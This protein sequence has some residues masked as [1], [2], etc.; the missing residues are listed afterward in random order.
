M[1]MGKRPH[2]VVVGG[3]WAGASAAS[4]LAEAG[5]SVTLLET[6][7]TLGGRA[8]SLRDGVTRQDVDNGQHAFL[9]AYKET[10]KFLARLGVLKR[11]RFEK[12]LH[13]SLVD[14]TGET[15]VLKSLFPGTAGLLTG[16]LLLKALSIKDKIFLTWGLVRARSTSPRDL[17]KKTVADWLTTIRQT[18]GARRIFWHPLCLATL[19]EEP[20]RAGARFLWTVLHRGLF[21]NQKTRALGY[22]TMPLGRLWSVEFLQYLQKQDGRV[23]FSKTATGFETQGDRVTAVRVEGENPVDADVFVLA[24]CLESALAIA[25]APV[26]TPS[27][28]KNQ[29]HTP[30]CSVNLWFSKS[31]FS[32]TCWG[33]LGL[34]FQWLYN[35]EALWGKGA[36]GQVTALVS[37]ARGLT[38]K[39]S[40]ELI[41]LALS[42]LRRAFPSFTEEPSHASVIWERKATP[43]ATPDF[44]KNRPSG[45]TDLH[46]FFFAG[47]WVKT[48]LP[49]TLEAACES[50]HRAAKM[51]L[52]YLSM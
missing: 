49:P 27:L 44:F 19:N 22:A 50:G 20:D 28:L 42:D 35:R 38:T 13:L 21:K 46:N 37:A 23:A 45:K 25:P 26:R 4:A 48:D 17:E 2:A 11:V 30:I 7:P 9:G 52:H 10:K 51:A 41:A 34:T 33:L 36:Q 12:T 47:D 3:G 16:L 39:S 40:K 14:G 18:A 29:D 24:G 6:R 43:S 5:V 32:E 15:S 31:P 1:S 8:G